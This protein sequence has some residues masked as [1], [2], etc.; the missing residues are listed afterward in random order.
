MEGR[1]RSSFRGAILFWRRAFVAF[2]FTCVAV[3]L[4]NFS[5]D[6]IERI[7]PLPRRNVLRA[8]FL[9]DARLQRRGTQHR[10][11]GLLRVKISPGRDQGDDDGAIS[12]DSGRIL[13][14]VLKHNA[15]SANTLPHGGTKFYRIVRALMRA[16]KN[17]RTP[18]K[19]F[20]KSLKRSVQPICFSMSDP[21][22]GLQGARKRKGARRRRPGPSTPEQS[23]HYVP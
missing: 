23:I 10:K 11:R 2:L 7:L 15:Y 16:A 19:A 14:A 1:R 13:P 3:P 18:P 5:R 21:A 8:E 12:P 4:L 6:R 22:D 20:V 9:L 17:V